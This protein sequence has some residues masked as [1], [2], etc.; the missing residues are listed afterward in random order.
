M[1]NSMTCV[2][3]GCEV[4]EGGREGRSGRAKKGL[5][6]SVSLTLCRK[7]SLA[8]S[9]SPSTSEAGL[10]RQTATAHWSPGPTELVTGA[11]WTAWADVSP[12]SFTCGPC[13]LLFHVQTNISSKL[14]GLEGK[15]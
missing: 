7:S 4:G 14:D 10:L 3:S 5:S 11:T 12:F 1:S 6:G 9:T 2:S 13:L 8:G 15:M